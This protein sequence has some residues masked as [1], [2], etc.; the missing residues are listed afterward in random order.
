MAI[1]EHLKLLKQG[2]KVWNEWR[3]EHPGTIP[4]FTRASLNDAQLLDANL[5]G[6]DMSGIELQDADLS[7]A[8]L[9][10]AA[11]TGAYLDRIK[12][13]GANLRYVNLNSA[14]LPE[15]DM[16]GA[17][18]SDA[19]LDT[20]TLKGA[21]LSGASFDHADLGGAIL[22]NAQM[23]ETNLS[24]ASL[25]NAKLYNADLK[26]ALMYRSSFINSKLDNADLREAVI[27]G[28]TFE[29]VGLEGA[30]FEGAEMGGNIFADID[31]RGAVGLGLV[32][33]H[34]PSEIGTNCIFLSEGKIPEE[35]LLGCGLPDS[36]VVQLPALVGALQPIEFYSCLISYS[37]KDQAFVERLYSDLRGKRV[38]CWYAPEDLRIGAKIRVG[39]DESIRVHDKLLLI[40][41]K[42][43][44]ES[45]WVEKEVETAMERERRQKRTILFPIRLDDAVL[46][47]ESGWAADV[48][49][50]RNIGDF[51][52]WKSHDVYS[53]SFER[54]LRDLKA[55]A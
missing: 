6:A 46:E 42:N 4:D 18:L 45:E 29:R 52:R 50:S 11:L 32:H 40:L 8:D 17:V 19:R 47:V 36:Y 23:N 21:Q 31:F 14:E 30:N 1:K 44:I 26:R 13:L 33:H 16:R 51:R 15:A 12:L 37:S 54:L 22:T 7:G 55:S 41:S 2:V 53:K 10:G 39:I 27:Y 28:T 5:R 9:E 48:R 35:F 24:D 43:S 49:R 34:Q 20:A 25:R 3:E 38:R